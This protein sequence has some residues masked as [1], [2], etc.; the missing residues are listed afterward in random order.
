MTNRTAAGIGLLSAVV[1]A[2]TMTPQPVVG[3]VPRP[4][5]GG[6][7]LGPADLREERTTESLGPGVTLTRIVRG[8]EDPSLAWTV[9]VA[10]PA[11][12]TSPDPDAPA[13]ALKDRESAEKLVSRLRSDGFDARTEQVSTEP[14]ADYEGGVLGWR[15]RVGRYASQDAADLERSRVVA[16]GYSGA[17]LYTGWDGEA[18]EARGQWRFDVLRV[19][20]DRF[21]GELD[22]SFGPDLETRERTSDLARSAG[23]VA[24]V[25]GGFFVFDPRAGAPGDPAGV[26][27]YEGELLS[28]P[29]G[30]RPALVLR[31]DARETD[32]VRTRWAG[33]AVTE[34]GDRLPLDGLNRVPGLIRNCGGTLDD[35]PTDQPLHD[36]TCTDDD[37]LV[38]FTPDFGS[39]TPQGE[40]V[41]VVLDRRDVVVDVRSP[42][43]GPL[44]AGGRSVQAT[45]EHT[46]WLRTHANIGDELH[47]RTRLI[48]DTGSRLPLTPGTAVINGGPEL[49]RDGEVHA[50]PATDG[51]VHAGNPSFYYGWVHKRHPR[52]LAGVDTKGRLVLVT[53]D[54]RSTGALGLSIAEAAEVAQALGLSQAINLDG[55]GSTTMVVDGQVI[56]QPSDTQGERPVGDAVLVSPT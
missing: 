23:A 54:G 6:L 41:E 5:P 19:D 51:M 16:A 27:V 48:G 7:P 9:E 25:N 52:T 53:A 43:G 45:G 47:V 4:S 21:R 13:T 11:G 49:V 55:G 14:M 38:A 26:G 10:I 37:E 22:G 24:A 50:T 28:E 39:V 33:A 32:I 44:P 31:P 18:D 56:N 20:P 3:A 2:A 15:V 8:G 34:S 17:T 46:D 1:L 12:N 35:T 40:G 30:G 29:V 36:F 42:R